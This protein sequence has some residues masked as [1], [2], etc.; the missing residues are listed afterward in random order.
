MR[1]FGLSL[2]FAVTMAGAAV[3]ADMP[4]KAHSPVDTPSW[5]GFYAGGHVGYALGNNNYVLDPAAALNAGIA[6]TDFVGSR[7]P[8]GGVLFGFHIPLSARWLAGIEAD[9]SLQDI[10]T[11]AGVV[12]GPD[13]LVF[14]A[15]Q[16]W[17]ASVRG[18]LGYLITP[19]TLIFGTAGWA[20]SKID[21]SIDSNVQVPLHDSGSINGVQVGFGVETQ[22]ASNWRGRLEYLHTFY[23]TAHFSADTAAAIGLSGIRPMVGLG[24]A[25]AIYHFGGGP[26]AQPAWT[27]GTVTRAWTGFY[28]GAAIGA[29]AAFA[30]IEIDP[31]GEIKGAGLSGPVPTAFAGINYRF[32]PQW[33]IGVEAEIA[34]SVRSSDLKLGWIGAARGRFGYLMTPDTLLYVT[35]GWA[36]TRVDDLMYRGVVAVAGQFLNGPQFGGGVEAALSQ[37]WNVRFDY[38]W[39]LIRKVD[40]SFPAVVPANQLPATALP[41]GHMARVGLVRLFD[42]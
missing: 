16:S 40:L 21:I 12:A 25:S 34:P 42:R 5:S 4:V 1:G 41:Q 14:T 38:Q 23:D 39:G 8:S 7:G 19:Q 37:D 11:I 26:T 9:A 18:R 17:S 22:I 24:R 31:G 36:G 33:L 13:Y 27:D 28:A 3:A 10:K 30:N 15:R 6:S 20:F 29:G 32:A 2:C 35:A